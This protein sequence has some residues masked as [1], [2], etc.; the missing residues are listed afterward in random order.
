MNIDPIGAWAELVV[1]KTSDLVCIT[2]FSPTPTY[3]YVNPS[4]KIVLGYEPKDLVGKCVWDFIHPDDREGLLPL[5]AQYLGAKL[6]DRLPKQGTGWTEKLAYRFRDRRGNWKFLETTGDLLDNDRIIFISR[7]VTESKALE[8]RL[9]SAN[10]ELEKRVEEKTSELLQANSLLR[11]QIS[12][13]KRLEETLLKSRQEYHDLYRLMRLVADNVPDLIW[14]KDMDDRFLFVNQAMCEKLLMCAGPDEAQGKTDMFFAG[15]EREAGFRHTFGEVCVNSD[16]MTKENRSAGRFL[17]DGLVRGKYLALDVHKAPLINEDGEMVGTVGSGRDITKER[18]VEEAL[19]HESLRN[20]MILQ[21][22]MDGF[23]VLSTEGDILKANQSASEIYGYS[24]KELSGMK[25][26]ALAA[27]G[28]DAETAAHFKRACWN[29]SD[30]FETLHRCREGI[31]IDVEMS[32]NF[33]GGG[34]SSFLYFCQGHYKQE[35][36]RISSRPEGAGTGDKDGQP[37]RNQYRAEGF[38]A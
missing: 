3:L 19:R 14:A 20:E 26:R 29:G 28:T 25:V 21:T 27:D 23:F 18:K 36:S 34:G 10:E 12:E 35:K 2:T 13:Q 17:E 22:A 5:L 38:A 16:A 30:H 24:P 31:S 11:E 15:R 37:G 6:A 9:R 33:V 7:D 32:T 1:E 8:A 4:N